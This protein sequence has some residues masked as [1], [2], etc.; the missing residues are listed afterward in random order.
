MK[1][2]SKLALC[3]SLILSTVLAPSAEAVV[4]LITLPTAPVVGG[5]EI[6]AGVALIAA[7]SS[8]TVVRCRRVPPRGPRRGPRRPGRTVCSRRYVGSGLVALGVLLL[9][10]NES[11]LGAR[12]QA[13]SDEAALLAGLTSA[14][15]VAVAAEEL[16]IRMI[17]D[18]LN[19]GSSQSWDEIAQATLSAEAYAGIQKLQLAASRE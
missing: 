4:G 17:D 19:A 7:G 8:A 2:L 13:P 3:G 5:I 14:E 18:E 1:T 6:G 12:F 9:D 15:A 11:Y 10:E 16:K